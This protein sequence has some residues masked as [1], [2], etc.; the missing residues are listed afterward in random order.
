M[1]HY[2]ERSIPSSMITIYPVVPY[3]SLFSL[4]AFAHAQSYMLPA[5]DIPPG[6]P[7]L[8]PRIFKSSVI[9]A[10]IYAAWLSA[11]N[12]M[13]VEIPAWLVVIAAVSSLPLSIAVSVLWRTFVDDWNARFKELSYLLWCPP[14]GSEVLTW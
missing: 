1:I 2:I 3:I 10:T 11:R 14:N 7:Y 9:P 4:K 8:V 12:E 5:I 13:H 6:I